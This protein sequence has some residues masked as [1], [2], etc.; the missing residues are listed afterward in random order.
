MFYLVVNATPTDT[1]LKSTGSFPDCRCCSP[2]INSFSPVP[3]PGLQISCY[4]CYFGHWT[5]VCL[6]FSCVLINLG[7]ALGRSIASE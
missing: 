7:G 3:E 2:N 4:H 1:G 6:A 5:V